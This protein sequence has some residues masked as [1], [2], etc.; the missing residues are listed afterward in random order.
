M[1]NIRI[2]PGHQIINLQGLSPNSCDA[3]NFIFNFITAFLIKIQTA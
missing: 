3:N 2:L 1:V